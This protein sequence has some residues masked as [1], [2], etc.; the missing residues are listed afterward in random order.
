MGALLVLSSQAFAEK[1]TL[2]SPSIKE[3]QTLSLDQVFNSFG[4]SGKNISPPLAGAI[5]LR[6][7]KVMPLPFTTPMPHRLRLVALGVYNL[8]ASSTGLAAEA[9]EASGKTH[10]LVP[11][12]GAPILAAPV[13]VAPAHRRR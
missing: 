10:P 4:C 6:A 13:L 5:H 9:G 11:Y 2:T 12:K 1:F 3:G 7:P 8:P